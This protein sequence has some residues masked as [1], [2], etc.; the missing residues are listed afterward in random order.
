MPAKRSRWWCL[1]TNPTLPDFTLQP[2]PKIS[3]PPVLG[4][5]LPFMPGWEL[6]VIHQLALDR[7]ETNKFAEFHSLHNNIVS[8]NQ[9][10]RTALHGWANQLTGCPCKCRMFPFSETR[11]KE[12]G[13]FAAL[14][15][16]G[17]DIQTYLG[18][19]PCTRH[20]HPWEMALIHG[21]RTNKMWGPNLRLGIAGLGQMASPVHS[22][23]I[24]SQ[25]FH[26]MYGHQLGPVPEGTLWR[27]LSG[28]FGSAA[29]EHPALF[30]DPNVQNYMGRVYHALQASAQARLGPASPI[31]ESANE[32]EHLPMSFQAKP[33]DFPTAHGPTR[34]DP[35]LN[36]AGP[37]E[38]QG[39]PKPDA[40]A[41]IQEKPGHP[42][43]GES[44]GKGLSPPMSFQAKPGDFPTAPGPSQ[45]T[46]LGVAQ[47]YQPDA[48]MNH[49]DRSPSMSFHAKT[50]TFQ[51]RQAL[52]SSPQW[53][54]QW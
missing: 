35:K 36:P 46:P 48:N 5:L 13:L 30:Q 38:S 52:P 39:T 44:A 14:I 42:C 8:M 40:V 31:G 41:N 29:S 20:M 1:I 4:D 47:V 23:W 51:Q 11:L 2:L 49:H 7:Y 9:P 18:E 45:G 17:T 12:K 32:T 43:T 26:Q 15:P 10:V 53:V 21:V 27:H 28:V 50:G 25:F 33:C 37:E 22:C 6:E 3:P 34:R 24:M 19:L 54:W 16:L